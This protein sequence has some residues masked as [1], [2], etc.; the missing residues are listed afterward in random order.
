ME[1]EWVGVKKVT[2]DGQKM[3]AIQIGK[4]AAETMEENM[5]KAP[6][7][8]TTLISKIQKLPAEAPVTE[9]FDQDL[10]SSR[11]LNDGRWYK[12]HKEHWLGWLRDYDGPGA[13]GR[14]WWD[15]TAQEIYNRVV[16]PAMV[17]WLGE[18]CGVPLATVKKAADAG[19]NVESTLSG[20]AGAVRKIIPWLL[21]EE[22]LRN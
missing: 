1:S 21:I 15:R 3:Y 5:T 17:L 9:R 20:K 19:R 18:A 13:Y 14:Q 6:M 8:R 11:D 7:T 16:N 22:R 10:R 12:N 2:R 4:A